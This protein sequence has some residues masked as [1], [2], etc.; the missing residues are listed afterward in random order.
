MK[1]FY[2]DAEAIR[3]YHNDDEKM[4]RR[5][6]A[7]ATSSDHRAAARNALI[8]ALARKRER[9]RKDPFLSPKI[10]ELA[11]Q[12][13]DREITELQRAQS[14]LGDMVT[15]VNTGVGYKNPPKHSQF[16]KG[17]PGGPGRPKGPTLS[18]ILKG[19]LSKRDGRRLKAIAER[20]VQDAVKGDL[21]AIALIARL[22]R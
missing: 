13:Y 15:P 10:K 9:D 18:S 3:Q 1:S 2:N 14:D 19:K 12:E 7:A 20:M 22:T 6:L 17:N 8:H 11:V 5:V 16:K 4:A 21:K